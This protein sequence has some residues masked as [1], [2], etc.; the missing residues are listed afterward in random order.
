LFPPAAD[1]AE[2]DP[3]ELPMPRARGRAMVGLC[4]ALS[5]G[6][7]ALDRGSDRSTV[8]DALLRI[9][10]IGPWTVGYVAMRALGDPDV[11]LPTDAGVRHALGVRQAEA[12]TISEAW[13]PWRSYALMHLW[14]SLGS[15]KD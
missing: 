7:V 5:E 1:L 12:A 10:G 2:V 8:R 14:T 4:R 13:R 9:P 6:E 15:G 11:F 3:E